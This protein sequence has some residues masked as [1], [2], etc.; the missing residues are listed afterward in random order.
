MA[1]LQAAPVADLSNAIG[2]VLLGWLAIGSR[3]I[4]IE[5]AAGHV[6]VVQ[7]PALSFGCDRPL[8]SAACWCRSIG[9]LLSHWNAV[10]FEI[11]STVL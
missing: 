9:V 2:L 4:A 5:V 3:R 11:N 7:R 1:V 8:G 10:D 6:E